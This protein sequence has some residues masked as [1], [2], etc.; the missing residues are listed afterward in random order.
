MLD[1][2]LEPMVIDA[3]HHGAIHLDKA[4]VGVPG[5]TRSSLAAFAR[6]STVMS[7]RP[8]VQH[9]V[10]HAWHRDARAGADRHQ[11][12]MVVVT[13]IQPDGLLHRDQRGIDLLLQIVRDIFD[14]CRRTRCRHRR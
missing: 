10:H 14:C 3:Q 1:N 9:G 8:E 11:Q 6:P 13:E 7:F 2:F 4:A 12:R 5:E